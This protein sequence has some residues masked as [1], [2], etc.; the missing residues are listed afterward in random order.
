MNLL[1]TCTY[2][3]EGNSILLDVFHYIRDWFLML[4]A[5]GLLFENTSM[6]MY[7][8]AMS[9]LILDLNPTLTF[10]FSTENSAGFTL[11]TQQM[12]LVGSSVFQ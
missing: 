12:E 3:C 1:Q 9:I 4:A 8:D 10:S 11:S 2:N 5:T 6:T 7:L